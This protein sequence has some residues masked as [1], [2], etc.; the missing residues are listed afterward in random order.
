MSNTQTTT[1][2]K[3]ETTSNIRLNHRKDVKSEKSILACKHFNEPSHNFQ[4]YA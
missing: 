3:S 1:R 4:Q 2:E